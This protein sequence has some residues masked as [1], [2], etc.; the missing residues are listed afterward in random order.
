M[1]R[2]YLVM[3]LATVP[4]APANGI[5]NATCEQT[6]PSAY[7]LY[8]Q[9]PQEA[10]PVS[11]YVSAHPDQI[12]SAK[13]ILVASNGPVEVTVPA[14]SGRVYFHLK[15]KSGPTRVV[16]IRRLALEGAANFRDLGG[17]STSDGHHVRWGVVYRSGQLTALT[18]KDYDYLAGIGLRLVCDFRI[19]TERGRAPTRWQGAAAPE[20]VP[21]SIDTITY[22]PDGA[23]I[24]ERMKLVY[25]RLPTDA[26]P[27]FGEI[28]HRLAK[29]DLPAMVHCSGGKDRTGVFS[30]ILLTALAV[31]F[32]AVRADFL[33][34][35]KFL[36]PYDK[37][38]QMA[39]DLQKRMKLEILP[40]PDTVRRT[41]GVDPEWLDIAFQGIRKTYG[42]FDRYLRDELRLSDSDL[43]ALRGRLLEE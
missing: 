12:D 1:R 8:F 15:P 25:N 35:N 28:L 26:G 19:D 6:G 33:L 10:G 23:T 31:P 27:Q 39:A 30:A 13:P 41:L 9:A 5:E 17:Y 11:I 43:A 16:S 24:Q 21:M 20:I 32:D 14:T 3:F 7:R 22:I 4:L 18:A 36:V 38:E 29:G 34:T 2:A 42:S 37:V 40:D